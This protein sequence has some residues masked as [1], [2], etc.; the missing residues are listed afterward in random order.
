M[1]FIRPKPRG[2]RYMAGCHALVSNRSPPS[3]PNRYCQ[4]GIDNRV[5]VTGRNRLTDRPAAGYE[6]KPRS[7][8][9]RQYGITECVRL[10]LV[11]AGP[12]TVNDEGQQSLTTLLIYSFEADPLS[13]T[14][15]S[16]VVAHAV[17]LSAEAGMHR[18]DGHPVRT[19]H[20]C[21]R[22][23]PVAVRTTLPPCHGGEI[24]RDWERHH[25]L[26]RVGVILR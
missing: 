13:R 2:W 15:V 20:R 7:L 16:E 26:T 24:V 17:S 14:E 9:G 25:A 8:G 3:D 19:R 18:Q 4:H 22:V 5:E 21:S 23:I 12:H 1:Y 11:E 10:C 6:D